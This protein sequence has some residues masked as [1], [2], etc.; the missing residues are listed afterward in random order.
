[1]IYIRLFLYFSI[2][3]MHILTQ[4]SRTW[5]DIL[6]RYYNVVCEWSKRVQLEKEGKKCNHIHIELKFF[7]K[8]GGFIFILAHIHEQV[9]LSK[10]AEKLGETQVH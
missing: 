2:I 5:Y 1:M 3:S 9:S 10:I 7:L 6:V 8:V 4:I